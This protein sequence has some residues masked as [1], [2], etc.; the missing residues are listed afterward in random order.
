MSFRRRVAGHGIGFADRD[1]G[2]RLAVHG[3]RGVNVAKV[4]TRG[5][6][7]GLRAQVVQ[8]AFDGL[9]VLAFAMG[10]AC[11]QKRQQGQGRGRSGAGLRA[12]I[13]AQALA[14]RLAQI[15]APTSVIAL[16]G[17]KPAQPALHRGLALAAA[18]ALAGQRAR[19]SRP[20]PS[21]PP[22]LCSSAAR[23]TLLSLGAATRSL[24]RCSASCHRKRIGQNRLGDLAANL[25]GLG[26]QRRV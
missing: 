3:S 15:E 24:G 7:P 22:P 21:K 4:Y 9:L 5:R 17:H 2:H 10:V 16:M 11:A 25:Y 8:P 19:A 23:G 13:A 18:T 26:L 6:H 1:R 20:R 14:G 12:G